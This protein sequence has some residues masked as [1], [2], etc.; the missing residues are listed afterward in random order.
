MYWFLALEES[1]VYNWAASRVRIC[2]QEDV[3]LGDPGAILFAARAMD[4]ADKW[5][6]GKNDAWRI[7]VGNAIRALARAN[8]S[9]EG[10][11]FQAAVQG[12]RRYGPGLEIPDHALDKHTRAGRRLERGLAHFKTEGAKLSP[13]PE[14]DRYQDRAYTF[15]HRQAQE[16]PQRPE[17]ITK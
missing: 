9:R 3:G 5:H 12:E 2:A 10:D 16:E 6:K 1:G 11:H 7:A 15:W 8:K 14:P 17:R 13:A 4:D